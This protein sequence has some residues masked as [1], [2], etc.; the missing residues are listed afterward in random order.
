MQ[1][2]IRLQS[3]LNACEADEDIPYLGDSSATI[4]FDDRLRLRLQRS[5]Q[6]KALGPDNEIARGSF[7][8]IG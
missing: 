4:T 5:R 2:F 3:R 8:R 7:G 6:E 1:D